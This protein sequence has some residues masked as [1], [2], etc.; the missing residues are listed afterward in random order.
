MI[1]PENIATGKPRDVKAFENVCTLEDV[2]AERPEATCY[3]GS[4]MSDTLLKTIAAADR[5]RLE[6]MSNQ[7]SRGVGPS[8][9]TT[10]GRHG[11]S[12]R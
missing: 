12:V 9:P 10:P 3:R 7:S 1:S 5:K 6:L 11:N 8:T 4:A 2:S